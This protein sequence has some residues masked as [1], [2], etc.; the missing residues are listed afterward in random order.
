MDGRFVDNG[1]GTITDQ[2]TGL[3]WQLRPFRAS[4]TVGLQTAESLTLGGYEDWRMP[5][6]A[7]LFS[8]VNYGVD[9]TLAMDP[10]FGA[11]DVGPYWSSTTARLDRTRAID[12]EYRNGMN[13]SA[14]GDG[15]NTVRWVRAVRGGLT[16]R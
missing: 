13:V 5:N 8:L 16:T 7:E 10:V 14:N 12:V 9:T 3:I 2:C 11:D 4:W 15:K 1:D 6:A